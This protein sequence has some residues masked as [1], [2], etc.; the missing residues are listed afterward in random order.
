MFVKRFI[1]DL[2][3]SLEGPATTTTTTTTSH[4][5]PI[6]ARKNHPSMGRIVFELGENGG[7]RGNEKQELGAA[8]EP[9]PIGYLFGINGKI[10]ILR[11]IVIVRPKAHHVYVIA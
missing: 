4:L 11:L 2:L 9:L 6:C 1:F 10:D 5:S 8:G 3:R 7:A